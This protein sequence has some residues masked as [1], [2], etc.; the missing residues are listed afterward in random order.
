MNDVVFFRSQP[1]SA[2]VTLAVSWQP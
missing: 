1:P 2:I